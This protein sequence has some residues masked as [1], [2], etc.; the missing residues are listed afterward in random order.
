[1]R[2]KVSN[3]STF[4]S[5]NSFLPRKKFFALLNL[6]VAQWHPVKSHL[7]GKREIGR[8]FLKRYKLSFT[9]QGRALITKSTLQFPAGRIKYVKGI[10]SKTQYFGLRPI[11]IRKSSPLWPD[12]ASSFVCS[13]Q[14]K[15]HLCLYEKILPRQAGSS[16]VK[17][18]DPDVPTCF[19]EY[20]YSSSFYEAS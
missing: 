11:Y 19:L 4:S 3:N 15:I 12:P 17:R 7:R 16:V 13:M 14:Y 6:V 18:Q 9:Y 1:M 8:I 10:R 5:D 2:E 20:K